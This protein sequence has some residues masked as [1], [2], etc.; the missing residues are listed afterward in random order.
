M[1]FKKGLKEIRI[2]GANF[3]VSFS[4]NF[5]SRCSLNHPCLQMHAIPVQHKRQTQN[6]YSEI[7]RKLLLDFCDY[8]FPYSNVIFEASFLSK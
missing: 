2:T 1:M 7:Y 3:L 5:N 8:L 4:R 6:D